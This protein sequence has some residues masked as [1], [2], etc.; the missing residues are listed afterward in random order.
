M[1]QSNCQPIKPSLL[2]HIQIIQGCCD[3]ILCQSSTVR[4]LPSHSHGMMIYLCTMALYT[5]LQ[6]LWFVLTSYNSTSMTP[7]LATL[8]LL[9]YWN[10]SIRI[11]FSLGCDYL[12]DSISLPVIFVLMWNSIVTSFMYGELS[13]FLSPLI[14]ER[15]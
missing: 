8:G 5:F 7:W 10:S 6:I 4:I 14:H 11:T 1:K 13:L 3:K 9:K 2:L 12:F 15:D